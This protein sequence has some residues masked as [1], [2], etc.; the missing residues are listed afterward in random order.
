MNIPNGDMVG[1]TGDTEATIVTCK[2][3]DDAVKVM[4]ILVHNVPEGHYLLCD[5]IIHFDDRRYLMQ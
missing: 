2:A 5:H 1:H 4:N 3:A